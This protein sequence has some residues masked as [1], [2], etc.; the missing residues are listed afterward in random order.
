[1]PRSTQALV[2]LAERLTWELSD[3]DKP[4]RAKTF[5]SLMNS[6][7]DLGRT[8]NKDLLEALELLENDEHNQLARGGK[9]RKE[10]HRAAPV[11]RDF[12]EETGLAGDDLFTVLAWTERRLFSRDELPEV[13]AQVERQ[14][15]CAAEERRAREA[16]RRK[17]EEAKIKEAFGLGGKGSNRDALMAFREDSSDTPSDD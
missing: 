5:R 2:K 17:R 6:V 13:R 4:V 9:Y 16:N 7:K 11:L 3:P 10:V 8:R 15:R 14:R 12:I 1:M